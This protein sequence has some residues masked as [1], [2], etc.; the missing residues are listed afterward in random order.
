VVATGTYSASDDSVAV[1]SPQHAR[2][3]STGAAVMLTSEGRDDP[4]PPPDTGTASRMQCLGRLM[5]IQPRYGVP[6][7]AAVSRTVLVGRSCWGAQRTRRSV[8]PCGSRFLSPA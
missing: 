4:V 3:L 5:S 6:A 1:D 8:S 7:A 2:A